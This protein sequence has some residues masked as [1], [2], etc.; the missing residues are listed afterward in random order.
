[1]RNEGMHEGLDAYPER[2]RRNLFT[3]Q[4]DEIDF[5]R[6]FEGARRIQE[7]LTP[8]T[9]ALSAAM[10]VEDSVARSV[11]RTISRI[12]FLGQGRRG[13]YRVDVFDSTMHLF[14]KKSDVDQPSLFSTPDD[15][16]SAANPILALDLLRFA[17]PG[18]HNYRL[19]ERDSTSSKWVQPR[20][21][22]V[23]G[24]DDEPVALELE[25]ESA[26]TQTWFRLIGPALAA[27]RNGRILLLDEIDASLHPRLS[28]RL[29]RIIHE[30][31]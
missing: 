15:G 31:F 5:R 24:V 6:G 20:L 22:F 30:E 27:L 26:G 21:H 4:R 23:H 10:R 2:R 12:G 25:E 29:T 8:T 11:G 17:D 9:L 19:V 14:V 13:F 28:A 7:L 3:R 16:L 18:I 1:M